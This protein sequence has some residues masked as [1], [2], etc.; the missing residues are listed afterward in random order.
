MPLDE[1]QLVEG[2]CAYVPLSVLVIFGW[3]GKAEVLYGKFGYR[4]ANA[5]TLNIAWMC[6]VTIL[7]LG[8][9]AL[10]VGEGNGCYLSVNL[11]LAFGDFLLF[12]FAF[13]FILVS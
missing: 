3:R 2:Q 13:V 11:G 8:K 5:C 12:F 6:Y 9:K 1:S 4:L 10:R 7:V